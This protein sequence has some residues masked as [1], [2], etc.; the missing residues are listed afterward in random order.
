MFNGWQLPMISYKKH[1]YK[2]TRRLFLIVSLWLVVVAVYQ[3][4][5][6]IPDSL[7]YMGE[8]YTVGD[9]DIEFLFDLTYVGVDGT[10]TIEQ[11]I[12]D[13]V[14]DAIDRAQVYVLIDM[15]LFN[16]YG[17]KADGFYRDL[18]RELTEKL[19]EKKRTSDKISIDVITDP[20]NTVYGGDISP[21]ILQLRTE[22]I[23]VIV[24]DLHRLRDSNFIYSAFW[25]TLLQWLK[26]FPGEVRLKHPFSGEGRVALSG[27]F[28]LLNF[29]A[30]HR[31]VMV[32]DNGDDM[33]T[34]ITSANPHG[35]SSE[36]ANVAVVTQ[37]EIW[38]S[39]YK[40]EQGVALLSGGRLSAVNMAAREPKTEGAIQVR[41]LTEQRIKQAI[42][43]ACETAGSS[44]SLKLAQFYM[45][46]RDIVEGLLDASANGA[47]VR[48]ILDPNK[49]A[50]GYE[51]NGIPNRQVAGDLIEKS[52][53][54]IKVRWYDTHGE[55]YHTKLFI[56][57]TDYTMTVITGSANLTRR[58]LDNYNL[59]MDV[60]AEIKK[61]SETGDTINAYFDRIWTNEQGGYT[62]NFDVYRD[63]SLFKYMLYR[64]QE[65]TGLG[66]F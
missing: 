32:T 55:Q 22:G 54:R 64:I 1:L 27:Y 48:I 36:H 29:K 46:D 13:T 6:T 18:S 58:N 21:E 57:E 47:E 4:H 17:A 10:R 40:A 14:F 19:I 3:T 44:D 25:R 5:K 65:K 26:I 56:K 52:N 45:A 31:K 2:M 42:L 11:Q 20:I 9:G 30:N 34:M 12:F 24:T 51:K 49:D 53:N 38:R 43:D 60:M 37:G 23:N 41:V 63:E 8:P 61:P 39:V 62:V 16:S 33:V 7:D 15:F 50:F 28:D 35:G 66:T 59:E